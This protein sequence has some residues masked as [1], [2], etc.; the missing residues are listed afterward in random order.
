MIYFEIV[1]GT[2][3]VAI[4][5]TTTS[6]IQSSYTQLYTSTLTLPARTYSTNLTLN[7]YATTQAS[8]PLT[9]GFNGSTI[10]YLST[11]ILTTPQSS[12]P[13]SGGLALQMSYT[14]KPYNVVSTLAGSLSGYLDGTGTN[15]RFTTPVGVAVD[16]SGNVY[17]SDVGFRIIR[18]I[19][20]E[21]VVTSL[22]GDVIAGSADGTGTNAQFYN[23]FGV[24]VDSAGNV[25]VADSSNHRIRRIT[26]AGVVTTFA[27]SLSNTS[28]STDGTG[29]NATFNV[30]S[31][32]A[33]DSAGNIYVADNSNHRIR[34]ITPAGVVTTFAGS[35]SGYLDGTGTNASFNRPNGITVDSVGNLYVADSENYRIRKITQAG[36]VTTIAGTGSAAFADGNGDS[37][38]FNGPR[39]VAV[40]SVGT[41]YVADNNNQRIRKITNISDV[42]LNSYANTPITGTLLTTFD[43]LLSSSTITIPG[44]TTNAK[45]ASF[46]ID[47]ASLPLKTSVAGVWNL[48]LYGRVGL[49]N[50]PASIYFEIVDGTT[51]VAIGSTTIRVVTNSMQLYTSTLTLPTRT[52]STNL[53][54]NIYATTQVSIPLTLG[55]NGSTISYLSTTIPSS[56][57]SSSSSS[58]GTSIPYIFDGGNPTSTYSVGPAFNA[59]GVG[60]TGP[61]GGTNLILQFRKGTSTEWSNVNP[62]LADGELGLETNTRNFKIGNG[63]TGW[64]GLGYGGIQ[65]PQGA[66]GT[67]GPAGGGGGGSSSSSRVAGYSNV[68]TTSLTVASNTYGTHFNIT[69]S[70]FS[71]LTLPTIT[72]S[73]DSNGFWVFRNNT[74]LFLSVTVT[75][76]TAGST[77]PTNPIVITPSN[78]TTIMVTFPGGSTSNY[79]LF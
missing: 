26:P 66:V 74:S 33:V 69:N 28:G 2:T 11:T 12:N 39:G 35:L 29:T 72:W 37:A 36:V 65:G 31:G 50:S 79:V 1:D 46:T 40:D 63:L 24:A 68:T 41:I 58:S 47:A 55:F 25:Y 52:Y 42:N 71:T 61:T 76:T 67:Q 8:S 5:S 27:G 32:V 9:L 16:S 57:S 60:T 38:S 56:S 7:I 48:A 59:G 21:G 3:T 14:T 70:A 54:L 19:T 77:A 20:P 62:T 4:G 43:P 49:S 22:A 34:K 64:N 10:S 17:V 6:M 73:N 18:K 78:S 13:L 51:T 45:V 53:T 44:G 15:A 75:Y 30:P 23:P